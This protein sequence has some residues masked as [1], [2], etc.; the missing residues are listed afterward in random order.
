MGT[1]RGPRLPFTI[2]LLQL[3]LLLALTLAPSACTDAL[4]D[5]AADAIT[6]LLLSDAEE[7]GNHGLEEEEFDINDHRRLQ[8]NSQKSGLYAR[9]GELVV[10]RDLKRTQAKR[11]RLS[12]MTQMVEAMPM[13]AS[14]VPDANTPPHTKQGPAI[15]AAAMGTTYRAYD[16]T[17]FCGTARKAGYTGDLVMAIQRDSNDA[18]KDSMRKYGAIT[19]TV[20]LECVGESNSMVCSFKGY[21]TKV[22]INMVRFYIYQV[23]IAQ[24]SE[25]YA[26]A[27]CID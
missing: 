24:G 16:V 18:F 7:F 25:V 12:K 3:L 2:S 23:S 1:I 4:E 14:L 15:F 6:E 8:S 9:Q 13:P 10:T 27:L 11:D 5:P 20:D 26:R 22:S 19:Y 17:N 21:D